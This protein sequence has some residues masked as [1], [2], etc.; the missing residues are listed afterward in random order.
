MGSVNKCYKFL[1][2]I[3][4]ID[5]HSKILTEDMEVDEFNWLL[6]IS[7]SWNVAASLRKICLLSLEPGSRRKSWMTLLLM[8]RASRCREVPWG[9]AGLGTSWWQWRWWHRPGWWSP[10]TAHCTLAAAARPGTQT[11]GD[12]LLQICHFECSSYSIVLSRMFFTCS[13]RKHVNCDKYN[14]QNLEAYIVFILIF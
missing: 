13:K 7:F 12:W 2:F 14:W 10:L 4:Y 8:Q 5:H 9:G 11:A 6:F 1:L 3:F